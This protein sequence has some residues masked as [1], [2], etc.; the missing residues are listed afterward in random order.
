VPGRL[1]LVPPLLFRLCAEARTPAAAPPTP[2]A[3]RATCEQNSELA[4]IR[5][6]KQHGLAL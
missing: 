5:N 4:K 1:L 6:N 2:L 3:K